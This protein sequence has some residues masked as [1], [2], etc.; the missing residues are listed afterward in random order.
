[1]KTAFLQ[2]LSVVP[3]SILSEQVAPADVAPP[4]ALVALSLGVLIG[5]GLLVAAIVFVSILVI[6]AIKK[7]Q[8]SKKDDA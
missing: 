1:M 4:G 2:A 8:T 5:L 7:K 6:R 3:I